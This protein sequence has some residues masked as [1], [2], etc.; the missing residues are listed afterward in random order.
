MSKSWLSHRIII[1]NLLFISKA[2]SLPN[3]KSNGQFIMAKIYVINIKPETQYLRKK[4]DKK[5]TPSTTTLI[6]S[7]TVLT[8]LW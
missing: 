5:S 4:I 7:W 1:S 2:K 8:G 3:K 6:H